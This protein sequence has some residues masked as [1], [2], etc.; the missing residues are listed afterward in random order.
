M[1]LFIM[2]MHG[3]RSLSKA[4][5]SRTVA[6][7]QTRIKLLQCRC[8]TIS[9]PMHFCW[10]QF[11]FG[12]LGVHFPLTLS[13]RSVKVLLSHICIMRKYCDDEKEVILRFWWIY[14]FSVSWIKKKQVLKCQ[15]YIWMCAFLAPKW[16]ESFIH[17]CYFRVY[18]SH[19]GVKWIWTS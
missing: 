10:L 8:K 1:F 12:V 14:T 16:L 2:F 9:Y 15:L 11:C 6:Q 17:I 13:S 3:P 18:P 7:K 5:T 19:V 4:S